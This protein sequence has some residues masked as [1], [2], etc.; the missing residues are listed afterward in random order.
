LTDATRAPRAHPRRRPGG[1]RA[2]RGAGR[3][4]SR[5]ARPGLHGGRAAGLV[6]VPWRRSRRASL[7]RARR[8]LRGGLCEAARRGRLRRARGRLL[9][10]PWLARPRDRGQIARAAR[11]VGRPQRL[12]SGARRRRRCR[13]ARV[14]G[15]ARLRARPP[16]L[17][18]GDRSDRRAGARGRRRR[19][20]VARISS[21][22]RRPR[23]PRRR[24]G[25]LRGSLGSHTAKKKSDATR[26]A[27][28]RKR[29]ASRNYELVKEKDGWYAQIAGTRWGP[30]RTLDDVDEFLPGA[31]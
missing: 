17:A 25:G 4:R 3:C 16:L 28:L 23:S 5:S 18:D 24:A 6:G 14:T 13:R 2:D 19:G 26:E 29:A 27:D 11:A 20:R 1:R 9:R 21:G 8:R 7:D 31:R 30:M 15:R 10:S 12:R 22:S